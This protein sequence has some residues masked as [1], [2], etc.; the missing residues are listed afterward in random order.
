[1]SADD[2]PPID[3][4]PID[5]EP[6]D[7]EPAPDLTRFDRARGPGGRSR[8]IWA[9]V[10]A[11]VVAAWA[12]VAVTTRHGHASRKATP[13]SAA[14]DVRVDHLEVAG[15]A[16]RAGLAR[17]GVERFAS[18]IDDRLY[19]FE[20]TS[21]TPTLVPL[22]EGH[23]TVTDQNG[24]SL[25][26]WTFQQTLVSTHPI[27]V[28]PFPA[29]VTA[30]RAATPGRWW[31]LSNGTIR[32]DRG[33]TVEQVPAGLHVI[34]AV[35]RG[36]IAYDDHG[37]WLLWNTAKTPSGAI[38]EISFPLPLD[39]FLVAS[40]R[41]VVFMGGCGSSGCNIYIY[42]V[43]TPRLEQI[44][45]TGVPAFGTFSP[46]GT[47]LAISTNQ[48]DVFMLDSANGETIARTTGVAP[49]SPTLPLSWTADARAL[50][51]VQD[52]RIEIRRATDG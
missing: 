31:L 8:W 40:P 5:L 47:R 48:G 16:M 43:D 39:Q 1:M 44:H 33:D 6:V 45:L 37:R 12:V 19:T 21:V 27:G 38:T 30:I 17:L 13:S 14:S 50:L 7:L 26:A 4:E 9:A 35:D 46:D 36:F 49:P 18:V 11:C 15:V 32:P 20:S 24:S 23:V 51:V 28:R 29:R 10:G 42:E 41:S 3:L 2:G 25:L 22:P 34:G 52:G